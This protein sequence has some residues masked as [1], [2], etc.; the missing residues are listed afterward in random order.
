MFGAMWDK[1]GVA[2]MSKREMKRLLKDAMDQAVLEDRQFDRGKGVDL[3]V[4][5]DSGVEPYFR[6]YQDIVFGKQRPPYFQDAARRLAKRFEIAEGTAAEKRQAGW[7]ALGYGANEDVDRRQT[8]QELWDT[9]DAAFTKYCKD[10]NARGIVDQ[11][12]YATIGR[13]ITFECLDR[14]ARGCLLSFWR[15]NGMESRQK[16]MVRDCYLEGEY[17]PQYFINFA[18]GRVKLRKAP[19]K[20]VL[21]IECHPEDVATKLA[22]LYESPDGVKQEWIADVDYFKQLRD[23]D[24]AVSEHA[25]DLSESRRIQLIKYG[26][27]EELRGRVPMQPVLRLLKYMEDFAVD[28]V[29]FHHERAKSIGILMLSPAYAS[30]YKVREGTA[31]KF[32]NDSV[33]LVGVKGEKEYQFHTLNLESS[34]AQQDFLMLA[35]LISAGVGIPLHVWQQRGDQE[36]Y[37][38]IKKMDTPFSTFILSNQDFWSNHFDKMFRVVLEAAVRAGTLPEMTSVPR[39]ATGDVE[40][41]KEAMSEVLFG[42]VEGQDKNEILAKA[43]TR[44]DREQEPVEIPTLSVPISIIFPDP[45]KENPLEQA[46]VLEIYQRLGIASLPTLAARAGF[47]W[48]AELANMLAHRDLE[49]GLAREPETEYERGETKVVPGL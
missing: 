15:E 10:P 44:L 47:N 11:V 36:V 43:K 21:E 45:V 24:R 30:K 48:Q 31:Y 25:G 23:F 3:E 5:D 7:I 17:F 18:D 14:A 2:V 33:L 39:Y 28:R 38:S 49:R 46:Q 29:K 6:Q 16:L 20:R 19:P 37:A 8:V 22:Y 13:G 40:T 4:V 42:V 12:Q 9:Q 35:Y 1:A 27:E 34:E 32:P 26:F 41:L